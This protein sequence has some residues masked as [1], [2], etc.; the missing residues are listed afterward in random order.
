ML[1]S[2]RYKTVSSDYLKVGGG[3]GQ[4]S[5]HREGKS[6]ILEILIEQS[7]CGQCWKYSHIE[8]SP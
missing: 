5:F 6:V 8:G 3:I 4:V 2:P 1:L 7:L